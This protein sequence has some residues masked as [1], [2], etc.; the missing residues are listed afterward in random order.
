[1][2]ATPTQLQAVL[3]AADAL[4]CA[5]ADQMVTSHE[6]ENLERAVSACSPEQP[7]APSSADDEP[8]RGVN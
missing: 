2:P 7:P 8:N 3:I 6:W 1:M 5:R 4:L